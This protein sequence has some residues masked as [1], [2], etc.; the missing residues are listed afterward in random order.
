MNLTKRLSKIFLIFGYIPKTE[1][2]RICNELL[3]KSQE[4]HI[5]KINSDKY[6]KAY[7][8]ISKELDKQK[9]NQTVDFKLE[10]RKLK[11]ETFRYV[12]QIGQDF[13]VESRLSSEELL[14]LTRKEAAQAMTKFFYDKLEVQI[15]H[16]PSSYKLVHDYK[17]DFY[18]KDNDNKWQ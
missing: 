11:S 1:Y 12:S 9:I 10:Y 5:E 15:Y 13:F 16:E 17:L 7:N 14:N 2:D 4:L 6:E 3:N 8:D 18:F